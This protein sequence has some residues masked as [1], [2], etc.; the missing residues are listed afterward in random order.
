MEGQIK[1][2]KE[3]GARIETSNDAAARHVGRLLQAI[4]RSIK[5]TTNPTMK[6]VDLEM[7]KKPLAGINVG[8]ESFADSLTGQGAQVVHVDWKPAAGSNE[9]L[10][11]ILERMREAR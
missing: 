9:R 4:E 3:S 2:L 5:P 6:P 7:L 8:V 10:V 11:G 1:V